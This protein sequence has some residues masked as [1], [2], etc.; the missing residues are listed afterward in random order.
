MAFYKEV[1]FN[2]IV[3][4]NRSKNLVI[5]SLNWKAGS[6]GQQGEFLTCSKRVSQAAH[7]VEFLCGIAIP[8]LIS[9]STNVSEI[10]IE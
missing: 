7:E 4:K 8:S 10:D 2:K 1:I 5:P 6:S 9:L 3:N